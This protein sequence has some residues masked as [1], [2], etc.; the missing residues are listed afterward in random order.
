MTIF[1][2]EKTLTGLSSALFYS[3][4]ERVIPDSVFE[5]GT[6]MQNLTDNHIVIERDAKT[7]RRVN[8]A[9]TKYAGTQIIDYLKICLLSC[10]DNAINAA[11]NYA[12]FTLLERRNVSEILSDKRVSDFYYIIK[13]VLNEKHRFT[14]FIRFKETA[15][16][17]LYAPYSPDNDITELLCPHF[18]SRLSA[19]PFIIHD[20]KRNIAGVSDGKNFKIMKTENK[21]ILKLSENEKNWENLWK[22]YYNAVNIKERRNKKQQNNLMPLRYRKFLPETYE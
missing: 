14:G 4:T 15:S 1:L 13:K 9:L 3:F 12:Y 19:V 6:V 18:V 7:A 5:Y 22:N 17:I 8:T 20:I 16:G 10:D 11:F 2:T 21:A